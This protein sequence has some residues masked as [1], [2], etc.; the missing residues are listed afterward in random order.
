MSPRKGLD[1]SVILQKAT[2]LIDENGLDQISLGMLAKELDIRPPS[3]Y[4]HFNGLQELKQKLA[5]L[6]VKRL[7]EFMVQTAVGRSGDDA[8]RAISKAYM[9]FARVHPGLYEASFRAPNPLDS[10]LQEA[11]NEV[12]QLGVK[13]FQGYGIKDDMAIHMLRG[14]RSF[15]HGFTSIEQIGDFRL[16]QDT[17]KS[18]S[19]LL[20]TYLEGIHAMLTREAKSS[21]KGE[22]IR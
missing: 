22:G 12:V 9:K 20:D 3:L 5:I 2:E 8:V 4:N 21:N 15:L 1:L 16:K 13:V 6:G 19:I 18:F 10:E 17:D 14:L 7:Y 11:Q